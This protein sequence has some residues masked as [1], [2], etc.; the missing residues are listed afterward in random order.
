[1]TGQ[2]VNRADGDAAAPAWHAVPVE[3]V[4][5]R[6]DTG[7]GGLSSAEAGDRLKRFGAN[8]L[9]PAQPPSALRRFLRQFNNIL[10][11][12]LLA[13][14]GVT[15]A[16][17]HYVDAGVIFGVVVVNAIIGFLQEGKAERALD[18]I[19]K[20]LSPQATVRR[21]GQR[22]SIAAE[23]LV[24]GDIVLLDSGDRVP[25]D[26]RLVEV[27]RL[28]I[29]EAV[30]TGESVPVD[31]NPAAVAAG[32]VVG[33]RRSMAFAGTL[34][35]RGVGTGV[36][37][38]TGEATEV[39]GIGRMLG[40]VEGVATPLMTQLTRFG[41]ALTLA[42]LV[43]T[44]FVFAIGV[45]VHGF[46][47]DAMFMAAVGLA[48]AA[49]PEGLPA[50]VTITLA[51]GVE[52]MARRNAIIRRLPAVETLGAV[53]VICSDKTGTLTRN[54]MMVTSIAT[55]GAMI[56]VDGQGYRPEGEFRLDGRP[57]AP[58][59]CPGVIP[60]LRS[61]L[62]CSDAGV[63][64]DDD[65]WRIDGDPTEGALVVAA[66]KAG[67]DQAAEAAAAPRIDVIPFDPD[68]Q[69]MATL[70]RNGADGSM[71]HVKGA[72][73]RVLAMCSRQ[74]TN[75]DGG[76]RDAPLDPAFWR[77]AVEAIGA[78]GERLLAIAVKPLPGHAQTLSPVDVDGRL[79]L[80]GLV[81]IVDPP[82]ADALVAVS[83]CRAAG[84]NVKMITG[85]HAHTARAIARAFGVGDNAGTASAEAVDV[86]TGADLERLDD[87]AFAAAADHVA[88]FAR[89][90]PG[91]KLRLVE[92]LQSRSLTVAMTGDGVNDAPALKRADV[93]IAMG[94]RGTE[95]AKEAS[96]IVLADDNFASIAHAVEE[97]RTVYANLQKAILYLL[98]TNGVQALTI[99]VAVLLGED[100]PLTP[101]QVLWVN[102]VT[103]V[104]LAIALAFEPA[105]PDVMQKPPRPRDAP[106]VSRLLLARIA[107]V[108]A[109]M[110]IGVIGLF[111]WARWQGQ[112]L[113][114]ARTMAVNALVCFEIFYLLS[115]RRGFG[116]AL[117]PSALQGI[118][119]SA[120]AIVLVSLLQLGFTYAP[121]LAALFHTTPLPLSAWGWIFAVAGGVFV[122]VEIEKAI[123]RLS[124]GAGR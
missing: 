30:L 76:E 109:L 101:V 122:V 85:D 90:T 71:I 84:I 16:L 113:Q 49:I 19:R 5:Q 111:E 40:E 43:L 102:M 88:V 114:T 36:V 94:G 42:I 67:L 35:T 60:L 115:V 87:A 108:S 120:L 91:D 20:M 79:T 104:T 118:G 14:G 58:D 3:D 96:Q 53:D 8:R 123:L 55:A 70:S 65:G 26:I 83:Q 15:V 45:F 6:L 52:R 7:R 18:A 51:I 68:Q 1:M 32:A 77:R 121:P 93:G 10:I 75:G 112:S 56:T 2:Q 12:V 66:M 100:L 72:P 13:A 9:T 107:F 97:G 4:L 24:P 37:V 17:A 38:A 78:R 39:G 92:A 47:L 23:G 89:T 25:A 73:E 31:K 48:V 50:I 69:Y 59:A 82:R 74:R 29:D 116:W 27:K 110:V 98:V 95:A 28:S 33:D 22:Q 105:E 46:A 21:D 63:H 61:A 103:A 54:E 124:A 117:A 57:L 99:I 41:R 106:L 44:L 86:L 64:A 80:L 34:V 119:P 11:Y 81:G 62:L